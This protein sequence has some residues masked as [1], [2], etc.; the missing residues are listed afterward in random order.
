MLSKI[1]KK[2][3][4]IYGFK[5]IDKNLIKNNRLLSENNLSSLNSILET[6]FKNKLINQLIQ[7]GSNDGERFDIINKF[8]KKYSFNC[9]LVEPIKIYFDQLKHNY[10]K[11]KNVVFENLAISVNDEINQLYKVKTSKTKYYGDHIK[12]ITSF[13]KKHLEKHGVKSSHIEIE[14]VNSISINNL[15]NKYG[16]KVDLLMIDA[17]GYDGNIVIDLLE[18]SKIQPIIVL[19]YIHIN[20]NVFKI[21]IEKLKNKNYSYY[22]INENLICFPKSIN[23]TL[24]L[25]IY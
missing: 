22:K 6:L 14:K 5:L 10:I 2:I 21:L 15:I 9:I 24:K 12:G 18:K 11:Q 13:D 3:A 20:F 8:I 17:E 23:I 25:D 16:N 1:I 7:V 4:G 19:E